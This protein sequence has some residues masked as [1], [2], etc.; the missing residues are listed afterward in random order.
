MQGSEAERL[1]QAIDAKAAYFPAEGGPGALL[2]SSN[3]L[4]QMLR[5]LVR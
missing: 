3:L 5:Q 4:F 2:F 1:L